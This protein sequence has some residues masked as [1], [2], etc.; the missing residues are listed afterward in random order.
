MAYTTLTKN[1]TKIKNIIIGL[2]LKYNAITGEYTYIPPM[3]NIGIRT[4]Y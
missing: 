3:I 2:I 4:F 1:M